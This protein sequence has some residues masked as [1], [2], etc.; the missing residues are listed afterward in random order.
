MIRSSDAKRVYQELG[1]F[2]NWSL[3]P[4]QTFLMASGANSSNSGAGP[5]LCRDLR[6]N[7]ASG[8]MEIER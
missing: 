6:D 3:T 4:R 2:K 7:D 1:K 8:G 5:L